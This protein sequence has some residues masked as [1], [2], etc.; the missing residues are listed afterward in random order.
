M[1]LK[2]PVVHRKPGVAAVRVS[3]YTRFG[4]GIVLP[5]PV[6]HERNHAGFLGTGCSHEQTDGTIISKIGMTAVVL[7]IR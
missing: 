2:Q 6:A 1:S 7:L 3:I 5:V 4:T